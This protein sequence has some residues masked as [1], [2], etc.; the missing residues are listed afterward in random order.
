MSA[1]HY[2]TLWVRSSFRKQV[3][4]DKTSRGVSMGPLSL[5]KR[6]MHTYK[7]RSEEA[8]WWMVVKALDLV[9]KGHVQLRNGL[10][11]TTTSLSIA[12]LMAT[13]RLIAAAL[14]HPRPYIRQPRLS[15][16]FICAQPSISWCASLLTGARGRDLLRIIVTMLYMYLCGDHFC[17]GKPK[18]EAI[19]KGHPATIDLVVAAHAD[20][21]PSRVGFLYM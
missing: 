8:T 10:L 3:C 5:L 7:K 17:T 13:G 16:D 20:L 12:T 15:V 1:I 21:I 2:D 14:S 19:I 6:R 11:G 18:G 9:A 4:R